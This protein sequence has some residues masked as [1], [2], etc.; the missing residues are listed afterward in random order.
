M[1]DYLNRDWR[2]H[3]KSGVTT[4]LAVFLPLLAM[5]I[6]Q[7]DLSGVTVHDI[8]AQGIIATGIALV[9]LAL[10]VAARAVQV[11]VIDKY[12]GQD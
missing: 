2:Y 8:S 11:L 7:Y 6:S 12:K 4:F 1:K 3:L 10:L 9:R 5:E